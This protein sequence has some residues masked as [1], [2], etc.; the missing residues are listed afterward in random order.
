MRAICTSASLQASIRVSPDFT[1]FRHSS[2][3][4]GSKQAHSIS[5]YRRP[6]GVGHS[7]CVHTM[8]QVA[9]FQYERSTG[10]NIF[11][12]ACLFDSLVRVSR[13]VKAPH[14]QFANIEYTE[15][16]GLAGFEAVAPRSISAQIT[17]PRFSKCC[18]Q[19]GTARGP[20]G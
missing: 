14:F 15:N 1:L 11:P 7:F 20:E 5:T 13:R 18:P 2:P 3:P 9:P 8:R 17:K 4:F 6:D 10:N 12:L 19:K 16:P